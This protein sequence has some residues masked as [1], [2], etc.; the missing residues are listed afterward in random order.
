MC[1]L[2]TSLKTLFK[3]HGDTT[4]TQFNLVIPANIRFKFYPTREEIVLE[5][6]FAGIPITVPLSSSMQE[7][8]DKI[9]IITKQFR[10]SFPLIYGSYLFTMW[11][12][13]LIPRYFVIKAVNYVTEK[14]TISLSNTPG[15]LKA[16]RYRNPKNGKVINTVTHDGFIMIAARLGVI[17]GA[18]SHNG[19][20]RFSLVSDT[21]IFDE[22]TNQTLLNLVIKNID[23]EIHRLDKY[24]I[25]KNEQRTQNS[26]KEN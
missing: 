22:K 1:S 4:S 10:N 8:Y 13:K 24:T 23:D 26:K 2:S 12:V 20:I 15:P 7:S 11:H 3:E 17:L 6:K 9:K 25:E 18:F 14:F 21:S 19:F 5:N 16:L